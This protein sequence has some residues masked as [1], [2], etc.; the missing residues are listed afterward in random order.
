MLQVGDQIVEINGIS[1]KNMTHAEAIEL[2][3]QGGSTVNLLIKR[4]NHLPGIFGKF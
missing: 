2:I 3:R 1:T 4:N